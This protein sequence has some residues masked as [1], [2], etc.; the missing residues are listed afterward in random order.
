[1]FRHSTLF[2]AILAAVLLGAG[3]AAAAPIQTVDCDKGQSV[4]AALAAGKTE[5]LVRGTCNESPVVARDDVILRGHPDG[6][7]IVGTLTLRAAQRLLVEGLTVTGPGDGIQVIDGASATIRGNDL[8]GN[9]GYGIQVID[10]AFAR[11]ENNTASDNGVGN[12][13]AGIGIT[14]AF[15]SGGGNTAV[16]N[17]FAGIE[18]IQGGTWRSNFDHVD[19]ASGEFA[20]SVDRSSYGD[21]RGANVLGDAFVSNNSELHLR[22]RDGVPTTFTGDA[23]VSTFS[24]LRFRNVVFNGATNCFSGDPQIACIGVPGP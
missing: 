15:A 11:I 14:R 21:L 6:G 23:N 19:A 10:G 4:S 7:T 20:L 24:V 5:L 16:N 12:E 9:D 22:D 2:P 18:V 8:S 13:G 3:G 17:G 1:M